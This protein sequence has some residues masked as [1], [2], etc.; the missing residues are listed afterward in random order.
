M[1]TVCPALSRGLSRTRITFLVCPQPNAHRRNSGDHARTPGG[2]QFIRKLDSRLLHDQ[3]DHCN[4]PGPLT[5]EGEGM[6]T[7]EILMT[8]GGAAAFLLTVNWVRSRELREK[9]AVV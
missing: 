3:G 2:R 5:A 9:Y 1:A 8:M 4:P 6:I 7:A